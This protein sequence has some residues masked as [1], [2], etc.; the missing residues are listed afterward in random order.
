MYGKKKT[1]TK[2]LI[3]SIAIIIMTITL[4]ILVVTG[5]SIFLGKSGYAVF[6]LHRIVAGVFF[7]A[8]IIHIYIRRDKLS[9]L[10]KDFI[11]IVRTGDIGR[12]HTKDIIFSP[13]AKFPL[14]ELCHLYRVNVNDALTALEKKGIGNVR[15]S[16]SLES[17][18]LINDKDPLE[19]FEVIIDKKV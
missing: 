3:T 12:R 4:L 14:E 8:S 10:F 11:S 18:S 5:I 7:V 1:V 15:P 9:K 17:I 16:D 13:L 19:L 6:K 2:D